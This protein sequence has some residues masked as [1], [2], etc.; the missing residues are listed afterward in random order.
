MA[1]INLKTDYVDATWGG[2]LRKYNLINN[3]DGT[4]SL[5]DVTVYTNKEKSF[6]G[7]KD[8][9]SINSA[10]NDMASTVETL[11]NLNVKKKGDT[12][13]GSLYIN[14][15]LTGDTT[16]INFSHPLPP[17]SG[18]SKATVNVSQILIRQ[19]GKYIMGTPTNFADAKNTSIFKS[20]EYTIENGYMWI[21]FVLKEGLSGSTNND[22]IAIN[23]KYSY[24]FN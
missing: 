2:G 16:N 6:F 20:T 21:K 13:T 12:I 22:G 17:L 9:N 23:Y 8:A 11:K 24:T 3:D 5:Q 19:N 15:T 14:G 7:A 1:N 4:V 10:I 18:V